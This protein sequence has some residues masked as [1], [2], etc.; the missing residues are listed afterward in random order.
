M[1]KA[2]TLPKAVPA[3][4]RSVRRWYRGKYQSAQDAFHAMRYF[5]DR[6]H[7]RGAGAIDYEAL[8]A[9]VLSGGNHIDHGHRELMLDRI[10]QVRS[11]GLR[12]WGE[13]ADQKDTL[14]KNLWLVW[15]DVR[16]GGKHLDQAMRAWD[17]RTSEDV[18]KRRLAEFDRCMEDVL[19]YAGRLGS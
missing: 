4:D 13:L 14:T 6:A 3:D 1:P 12:V 9:T 17:V 8:A 15:I 19:Y 7:E 5:Q 2:P 18:A 16:F 10:R 11:A